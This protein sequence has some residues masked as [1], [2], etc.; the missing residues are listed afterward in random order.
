MDFTDER[1]FQIEKL[2]EKISDED[3][4]RRQHIEINYE[5][6]KLS[7]KNLPTIK[8]FYKNQNVFITGGNGF[9][10]KVLI[11]KLLRSCP[12]INK[13]YLLLRQKKGITPEKRLNDML[14]SPIFDR[15][16]NE[17]LNSVSK[18]IIIHGDCEQTNIGMSNKDI[19]ILK[20]NVN[21]IF[22]AAA[23]VRFDDP[24]KKAVLMNTR[25]ARDL[26]SIAKQMKH[27]KV[28][29]HLSTAYCN[30]D[31]QIIHE[32]V[33]PQQA[34]WKHII[35]MAETFDDETIKLLTAKILNDFPNTYTFTKSLAENVINDE[36]ENIPTVIYRPSIVFSS[37]KEPIPG[38][39]DNLNGPLGFYLAF[40]TGLLHVCYADEN[41]APDHVPVD[42]AIANMIVASW[43]QANN[44]ISNIK[45]SLVINACTSNVALITYR[46]M[47]FCSKKLFELYPFYRRIWY[48]FILLIT[49]KLVFDIAFLFLQIIPSIF[50]QIM[51]N[52]SGQK[53]PVLKMCRKIYIAN[54]A[55][56]PFMT[57]QWSFLNG[58]Y[59]SLN[60]VVKCD[61]KNDFC[62]DVRKSDK[63]S[64]LAYG[65]YGLKKY[66]L[67]E[68]IDD[69]NALLKAQALYK[70]F[71][72]AH[73]MVILLFWI[74]FLFVFYKSFL[75]KNL[76]YCNLYKQIIYE[77]VYP[78]QANWKHLIQI[79]ET[80]DDETIKL[81]TAK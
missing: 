78:Q 24:L 5:L 36:C 47:K 15:L 30:I 18:L 35:H 71:S 63:F 29:V 55:L 74:I 34:N 22:H 80:F 4:K 81:L 66:M 58:N 2:A 68:N 31:K 61:D 51:V 16:K 65:L 33:Y 53:F 6:P 57:N 69:K 25:S 44:T 21:I 17:N 39:L 64:V 14:E 13:I 67:K 56:K 54:V 46:Y 10:G 8:E 49:N 60:K 26:I 70:K 48:P 11:E 79:A 50:K 52:L 45:R 73:R 59:L 12:D 75:L 32:K 38:W 28:F 23:S 62:V 20:E 37:E 1:Y 27:L 40:G 77:K 43:Y 72:M 9:M 3:S 7:D 19:E 42:H 41:V 76:T